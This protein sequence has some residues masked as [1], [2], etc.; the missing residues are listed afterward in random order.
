MAGVATITPAASRRTVDAV[1]GF[2]RFYTRQIGLLGERLFESPFSLSEQ[3]VLYELAYR[4]G[5]TASDLVE[6]LGLDAGYLSRMLRRFEAKRLIA[7]TSSPSDG[8]QSHLRLTA[9][10]RSAFA[11]LESRARSEVGSML[12][13][14]SAVE[15]RQIVDA[16]STIERALTA[17][18]PRPR[19]GPAPRT[20]YVLRA[21]K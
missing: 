7:R 3:R 16:M 19:S 15:R 10:G 20:P 12:R 2:N 1:R 21:H 4:D 5:P 18:V 13:N 17:P 6:D 14:L 11:P 9:R 8:R